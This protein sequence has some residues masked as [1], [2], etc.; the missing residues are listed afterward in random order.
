MRACQLIDKEKLTRGCLSQARGGF[1]GSSELVASC[2]ALLQEV[3]Q[4]ASDLSGYEDIT[5][6]QSP[7]STFL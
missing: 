2:S 7:C 5:N 6:R 1:V 4:K 3:N